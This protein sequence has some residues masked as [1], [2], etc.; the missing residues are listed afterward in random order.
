MA[1]A[2][3][4]APDGS[5]AEFQRG[6]PFGTYLILSGQRPPGHTDAQNTASIHQQLRQS[7]RSSGGSVEGAIRQ[8]L[9]HCN[10]G[11]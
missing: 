5:R 8:R 11:A 1:V 4:T 2:G 7:D 3:N 9:A 6:Q 10:T